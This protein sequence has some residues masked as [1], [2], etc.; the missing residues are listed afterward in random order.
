MNE[1]EE[2]TGG[3]RNEAY[4]QVTKQHGKEKEW[5]IKER[6]NKITKTNIIYNIIRGLK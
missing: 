4:I 3:K 1:Q 2:K 6:S 5:N